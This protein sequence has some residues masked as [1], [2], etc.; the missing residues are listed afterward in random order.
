MNELEGEAI[1]Q[2]ANEKAMS[3]FKTLQKNSIM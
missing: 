1:N 3:N 2:K